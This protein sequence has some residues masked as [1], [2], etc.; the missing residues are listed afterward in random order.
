MDKRVISQGGIQTTK[1]IVINLDYPLQL[2]ST[3]LAD[4]TT[5]FQRHT[6]NKLELTRKPS[7]CWLAYILLEVDM[8]ATTL[9]C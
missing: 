2:D 7:P 9:N 4:D 1:G 6:E 5:Y 3:S 8:S